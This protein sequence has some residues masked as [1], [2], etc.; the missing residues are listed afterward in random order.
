MVAW[1]R[2]CGIGLAQCGFRFVFWLGLDRCGSIYLLGE[3]GVTSYICSCDFKCGPFPTVSAGPTHIQA[4]VFFKWA[5]LSVHVLL[6]PV[7]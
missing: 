4:A 3:D 5:T 2:E 7:W 6:F 1:H